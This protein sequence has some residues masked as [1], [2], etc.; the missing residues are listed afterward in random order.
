MKYTLNGSTVALN[1]DILSEESL[2]TMI[3]EIDSSYNSC[4]KA[5]EA[6]NL[7]SNVKTMESFGYKATEGLGESIKNGAKAVWEKI[8]SFFKKIVEFFKRLFRSKKIENTSKKI[9]IIKKNIKWYRNFN[10]SYTIQYDKKQ[11]ELK[12]SSLTYKLLNDTNTFD[13]KINKFW[14]ETSSICD[15]LAGCKSDIFEKSDALIGYHLYDVDGPDD[16]LTSEDVIYLKRRINLLVRR[17]DSLNSSFNLDLDFNDT[18]ITN[19]SLSEFVTL[20]ENNENLIDTIG[21]L[22]HNFKYK[23]KYFS[24]YIEEISELINRYENRYENAHINS[25][26]KEKLA[27]FGTFGDFGNAIIR[28]TKTILAASDT[29]SKLMDL[30]YREI[31]DFKRI[32]TDYE[33]TPQDKK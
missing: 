26:S 22:L 8:K 21:Y 16:A 19:I 13:L 7:I 1:K 18:S 32:S 10:S 25:P 12:M 30:M 31:D 9:E 29:I 17:I 11:K 3:K 27:F 6:Y 33:S 14:E 24:E 23:I 2:N 5:I 15:L 28:E 20:Y 4:S